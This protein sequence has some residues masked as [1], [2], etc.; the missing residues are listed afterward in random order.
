[1]LTIIFYLFFKIRLDFILISFIFFS[2]LFIYTW[3]RFVKI[4]SS[5][6]FTGMRLDWM[7]QHMSWVKLILLLSGFVSTLLLLLLQLNVLKILIPFGVVAFLYVGK[8]PFKKLFNLR[9]IPFLKAHLVAGVW[10]GMAVLFPAFQAN[11]TLSREVW[12]LFGSVYFFILSLA[13]IFDIRDVEMDEAD[14]KTMPQLVGKKGA[15]VVAIGLSVMSATCLIYLSHKL[16]FPMLVFAALASFLY[17]IA[18]KKR[19][20][21]YFS[22]WMDGLIILFSG[23][24]ISS[25]LFG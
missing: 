14:K 2:T 1:M 25:I 23:I 9:D 20:D 16:L 8:F 3:Q 18:T 7:L 17:F 19:E 4:K 15:A 5:H 22:F 21:F 24:I 12:I 10:A 13:I 11:F 6:P